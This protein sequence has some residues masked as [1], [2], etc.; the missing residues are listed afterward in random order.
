MLEI[1]TVGRDKSHVWK[2][3]TFFCRGNEKTEKEKE[4]NIW[5]KKILLCRGDEERRRKYIGKGKIVADR[6]GRTLKAL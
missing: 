1:A 4:E 3:N 2:K 5:R 6:T